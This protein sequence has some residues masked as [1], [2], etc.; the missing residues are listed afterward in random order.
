MERFFAFSLEELPFVIITLLVAFTVHEFSHAFVAYKFGDPTAKNQGR[1]TLNPVHHLDPFGALFILLTGFGWARPVPVNRKFFKKPRLA[2][3][4]VS[5]AGPL[6]NLVIAVISYAIMFLFIS[7][8]MN[9]AP[10]FLIDL[11]N[12][13]VWLNVVLFVFN[14]LPLPPLDGY[15]IIEDLAP[16]HIRVK[17]SQWEQYGVLIFLIIVITPLYRVTIQPIFSIVIPAILKG[18]NSMFIQLFTLFS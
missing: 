10:M 11:L 7:S 14:L 16:V 12:M 1:L 18:F 4:L 13:M 6:S 5:L 9:N 3:V 17:M 15:R 2:G 8:G